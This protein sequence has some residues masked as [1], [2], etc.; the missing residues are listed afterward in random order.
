M[1]LTNDFAATAQ[2]LAVDGWC[3]LPHLMRK[4]QTQALA[5]ECTAMY[6]RKFML[7]AGTGRGHSHS[8]LR[9]DH[10]RWFSASAL[11]GPQ[12]AFQQRIDGLREALNRHLFLGLVGTESHYSVYPPGSGY[13]RHLDRIRDSDARVISAVFYLNENWQESDGGA[14]RLYLADRTYRD[15]FPH[16]GTLLLFL[17]A[18][19]EHQVLP[20]TRQRMSIACW[21]R[22]RNLPLAG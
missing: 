20:A 18:Q 7:A 22:Q 13:Q 11:S 19:F 8:L 16:A 6:E 14:L 4:E 5:Q 3:S 1:P 17:S 10:T 15:V 2:T 21:M 9:G 12:Q